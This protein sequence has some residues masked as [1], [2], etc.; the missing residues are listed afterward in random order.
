MT[1]PDQTK[2]TR[3]I[4][5]PLREGLMKMDMEEL[6]KAQSASQFFAAPT[7]DSDARPA[8]KLRP[9]PGVFFLEALWK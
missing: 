9:E 1:R 5:G 8:C 7:V 2:N 6:L 4:K 3:L